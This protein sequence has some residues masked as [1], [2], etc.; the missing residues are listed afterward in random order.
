M[1]IL[2]KGQV[3]LFWKHLLSFRVPHCC[4]FGWISHGFENGAVTA[5]SR[6]EAV[7]WALLLSNSH[8]LHPCLKLYTK[9]ENSKGDELICTV[10]IIS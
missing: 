8:I 3:L 1:Y 10:F 6:P 5:A 9:K 7:V 4:K 2:M